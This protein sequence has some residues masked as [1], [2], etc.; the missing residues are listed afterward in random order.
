MNTSLMNQKRRILVIDDNEAIHDD[1][2][3]IFAPG[4]LP[5]DVAGEEAAL[6][7]EAAAV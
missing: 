4:R 5:S 1:F 2:H 3:K 6:F 7:G